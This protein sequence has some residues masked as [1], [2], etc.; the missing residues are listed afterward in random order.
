MAPPPP[1]AA[2]DTTAARA[3]DGPTT[4]PPAR[5]LFTLGLIAD[6]Q[7]ADMADT[8]VEGRI[9]RFREAP[10]KLAAAVE[11]LLEN[12]AG[13][14]LQAVLTLGDVTNG[15]REDPARNPS[16]LETPAAI[17]DRLGAA[18]IPTYHV[19]GN[20]CLDMPQATVLARL[21]F[22]AKDGS[23]PSEDDSAPRSSF[24]STLLAPG[25]RLIA[26]DTTELSGHSHAEPSI[27]EEAA[28]YAAAHPLSE[29][30]PQ[31][32]PWNGGI[33]RAQAAWLDAALD[34]AAAAGER[35]II[36]AHHQA[37]PPPAVRPSHAAWNKDEIF[38]LVTKKR[39]GGGGGTAEARSS[40]VVAY[41]A[42]H[43]HEGGYACAG[44]VHWL[45]LEA[46]VEAPSGSTAWATVEVWEGDR[47]EVVGRGVATS[48][49][50]KLC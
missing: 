24:Y 39:A 5:P 20:H 28:A 18:G 10:G 48:R 19:L 46:L 42:G 32:S 2:A 17:L 1:P 37:G 11:E 7:Y 40:P 23:T 45:T 14:S 47:L 26:L 12:A 22:P 35:V 27:L 15:N 21:G 33:G 6:I 4:T 34:A 16:D 38:G 36:A 29:A 3:A 8:H 31:M 49:T 30:E 50:L 43:D 41:L 13:G 25:W 44:G 9:Q